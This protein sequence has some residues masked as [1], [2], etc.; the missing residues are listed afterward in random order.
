[1]DMLI[2]MEMSLNLKSCKLGSFLYG[3]AA[4]VE[5]DGFG[6]VHIIDEN[7][8]TVADFKDDVLKMRIP[9]LKLHQII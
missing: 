3:Y 2:R 7:F 6:E 5:S 9:V 4:V 8:N 1:M